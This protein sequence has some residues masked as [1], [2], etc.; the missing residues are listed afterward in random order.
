MF[1]GGAERMFGGGVGGGDFGDA[2]AAGVAPAAVRGGR[3]E[4]DVVGGVE[5]DGENV[6]LADAEVGL[7]VVAGG[8]EQA[9]AEDFG[10]EVARVGGEVAE[11]VVEVGGAGAWGERG[12]APVMEHGAGGGLYVGFGEGFEDEIAAVQSGEAVG[13][14][15]REIGSGVLLGKAVLD[16]L[17][18]GGESGDGCRA[19]LCLD[20]GVRA[21]REKE[22][23]GE[24]FGEE[25]LVGAALHGRSLRGGGLRGN[26]TWLTRAGMFLTV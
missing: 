4:G 22:E 3:A 24:E 25:R 20:G 15:G 9:G 14:D 8:G 11:E 2:G 16:G 6:V 12:A 26:G 13:Q 18:V 23:G 19:G 5:R 1:V 21:E 17:G 10:G 7:H